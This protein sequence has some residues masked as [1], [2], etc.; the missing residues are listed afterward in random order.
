MHWC[1][2]AGCL[3]GLAIFFGVKSKLLAEGGPCYL[4]GDLTFGGVIRRGTVLWDSMMWKYVAG[5]LLFI[6]DT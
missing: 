4:M 2:L 1:D 6:H 3:V 5:L